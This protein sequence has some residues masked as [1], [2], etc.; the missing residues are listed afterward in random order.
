MRKE[1]K[2]EEREGGRKGEEVSINRHIIQ[3]D[4]VNDRQAGRQVDR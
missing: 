2:E 4:D 1:G 3:I